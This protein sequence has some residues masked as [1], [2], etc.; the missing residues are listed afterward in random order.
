VADFQAQFVRD[1]PYGN[2]PTTVMDADILSAITYASY[3][4][5]PGLFGDQG[6]YTLNFLLLSAHY[7]VM[8]LRSSSQGIAGAFTFLDNSRSAGSVSEG[9]QI[10]ERI[11]EDPYFAMLCKTNYGAQYLFNILPLLSGQMF[12]ACGSTNP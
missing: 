12:N 10:P 8:N 7:L 6:S 9:I 5:N 1:F 11:Q 2:N 3:Q 4:I